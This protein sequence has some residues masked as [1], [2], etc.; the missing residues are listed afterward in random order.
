MFINGKQVSMELDTG[1]Q[2]F[3]NLKKT[4]EETLPGEK[5]QPLDLKLKTYEE[6]R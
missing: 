1:A 4:R 6:V 2:V 5:L 3:I